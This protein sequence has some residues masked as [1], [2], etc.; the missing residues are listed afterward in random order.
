MNKGSKE[1]LYITSTVSG[2][3]H[4]M[5]KLLAFSFGLYHTNMKPLC[6]M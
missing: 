4:I 1:C 3:K 6:D 5:E 2:K